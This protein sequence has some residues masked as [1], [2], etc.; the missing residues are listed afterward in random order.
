MLTSTASWV[1]SRLGSSGGMCAPSTV[2]SSSISRL[3]SI[4]FSGPNFR[5]AMTSK[6][7]RVQIA[8]I[9]RLAD[10]VRMKN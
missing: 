7:S 9:N 4:Q 10:N 8:Y 1:S 2:M 3:L 5:N 6:T